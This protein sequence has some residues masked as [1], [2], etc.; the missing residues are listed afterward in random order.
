MSS[1][2]TPQIAI[3]SLP[4]QIAVYQKY[5]VLQSIAGNLANASLGGDLVLTAGM[6]REGT[7]LA[8][9]STIAGAAFLGIDP[10]PQRLKAAM[11]NSACDFMVNNLDEA[12]RVLKNEVRKKQPVSVGLLGN[13]TEILPQ[14]VERGVQPDFLADTSPVNSPSDYVVP[15]V[16]R[17]DANI[18][19]LDHA[20]IPASISAHVSAFEELTR[21]GAHPLMLDDVAPAGNECFVVLGANSS[22]DLKRIEVL[23][24]SIL[25][26]TTTL[27]RRWMEGARGYFRR[28]TPLE[29]VVSLYPEEYAALLQ[30]AQESSF[31]NT[32][33]S[34]VTVHLQNQKY[35]AQAAVEISAQH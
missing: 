16:Q 31:R 4:R 33:E 10:R 5:L 3:N 8:M 12:L 6:G 15:T 17:A 27:R 28:H 9:A 7:E 25:P 20:A 22:Q 23:V 24:L 34:T 13:A 2:P 11:R 19:K 35:D 1:Q 32:L 14:M 30:A 26:P 29:R 21:R 18:H